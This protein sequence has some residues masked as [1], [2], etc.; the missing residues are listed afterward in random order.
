MS[1]VCTSA[2][3]LRG[4]FTM[5]TSTLASGDIKQ[6]LIQLRAN[7]CES[8]RPLLWFERLPL[9]CHT[10]LDLLNKSVEM[11]KQDIDVTGYR[12]GVN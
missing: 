1:G 5:Y 11:M 3:S 12:V 4:R 2:A 9:V 6:G 7:C 8:M 10:T